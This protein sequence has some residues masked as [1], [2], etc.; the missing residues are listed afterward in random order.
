M[1]LKE[2]RLTQAFAVDHIVKHNGSRDPLFWDR[3]NWQSLCEHHHNS[4]KQSQ[5]I[6]GFSTR[7]GLDGWPEDDNHPTNAGTHKE[8]FSI[9]HYVRPSGIPVHLVCGA[10]G[11]GKSTYARDHAR[12]EDTIIDF[13]DIRQDIGASRYDNDPNILKRVFK[14]RDEL[15]RSLADR[16]IGAAWLVVMAPTT[17]ERNA[18][19]RALGNTTIHYINATPDEC[20]QRIA[21]DPMREG[22][23]DRLCDAVDLYFRNNR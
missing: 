7:V 17:A 20:K 8:S 14:R 21:A 2:A 4:D 12:P 23:I 5:D 18:W 19:A 16:R 13:D 1:C 3:A 11:S 10:P 15:I 22:A 9:P 6:R